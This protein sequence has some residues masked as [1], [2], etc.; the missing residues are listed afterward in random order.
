MD[1]K[2]EPALFFAVAAAPVTWFALKLLG[3]I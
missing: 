1:S 3:V 2:L